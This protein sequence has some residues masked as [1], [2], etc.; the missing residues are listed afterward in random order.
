MLT[1]GVESM[2]PQLMMAAGAALAIVV[3]LRSLRQRAARQGGGDEEAVRPSQRADR[4]RQSQQM[5]GDLRQMMVELEDLTRRFS[6]QLDA[7]SMRLERLLEEADQKIDELRRLQQ[8]LA[9]SRTPGEPATPPAPEPAPAPEPN[10]PL[11]AQIYRL[12]DAGKRPLDIA[13][14]LDE[15]VGKVEL[16]LNLRRA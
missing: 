14:Q 16:I 12:A 15:H 6:A 7:K 3:V 10:D 2:L 1:L 13:R 8:P 4:A 5:Q 11:A 9:T